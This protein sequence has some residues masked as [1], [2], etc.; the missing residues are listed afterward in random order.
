MLKLTYYLLEIDA[1]IFDFLFLE[2]ISIWTLLQIL[3][4]S[5]ETSVWLVDGYYYL[6]VF[7][8]KQTLV[9][10]QTNF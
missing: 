8:W 5:S 1:H 3:F 7:I 10:G 9:L 6:S 4:I 2:S